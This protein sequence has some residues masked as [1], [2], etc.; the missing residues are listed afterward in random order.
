MCKD[1]LSEVLMVCYAHLK[2]WSVNLKVISS[3]L[4]IRVYKL[5]I[6]AIDLPRSQNVVHVHNVV[7]PIAFITD[8][9][10]SADLAI[11]GSVTN[12]GT[13]IESWNKS[14]CMYMYRTMW[15]CT[16]ILCGFC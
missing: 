4:F 7:M 15:G 10:V 12:N 13:T 2:T 16:V 1:C 6:L 5:F 14:T 11:S 9:M 8:K 3:L